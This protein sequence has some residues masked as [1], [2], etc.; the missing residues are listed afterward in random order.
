LVFFNPISL[1][2]SVFDSSRIDGR[3]GMAVDGVLRGVLLVFNTGVLLN[4]DF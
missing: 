4:V 2:F 3:T 1:V